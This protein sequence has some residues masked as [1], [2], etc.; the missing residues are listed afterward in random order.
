[1]KQEATCWQGVASYVTPHQ[2]YQT[3]K[4]LPHVCWFNL[5]QNI[6]IWQIQHDEAPPRDAYT[7]A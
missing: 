3:V 4:T 6:E 7:V 5:Q 2:H 1:M